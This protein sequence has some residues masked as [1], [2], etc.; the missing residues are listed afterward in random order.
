MDCVLKGCVPGTMHLNNILKISA[1]GLAR[2]VIPKNLLAIKLGGFL[3]ANQRIYLKAIQRLGL[4]K[5]L[6]GVWVFRKPL[7]SYV[8]ARC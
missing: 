1:L 5:F 7:S 2:V 6:V 3:K 4:M 8:V